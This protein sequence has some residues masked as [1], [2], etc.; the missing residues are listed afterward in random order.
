MNTAVN[1]RFL[2]FLAFFFIAWTFPFGAGTM[3]NLYGIHAADSSNIWAVGEHGVIQKYDGVKW[4]AQPSG[5]TQDL[6]AVTGSSDTGAPLWAVGGTPDGTGVVLQS[7]DRVSWTQSLTPSHALFGVWALDSSHAWAVGQTGAIW[8][9]NG[10]TWSAQSSGVST[11]LEAVFGI[12]AAHVWAVGDSGTILFW[13]GA[14]WA[15]QASPLSTSLLALWGTDASHIWAVGQ[16]AI[17]FWNGATWALQKDLTATPGTVLNGIAGTNATHLRAAGFQG[18][19]PYALVSTDGLTWTSD[20]LSLAIP[21]YALAQIG[22]R[23]YA[24]GQHGAAA[25]TP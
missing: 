17:L 15:T 12:D 24:V 2:S 23:Y 18:S 1:F 7:R 6:Y 11:P 10:S 19:S 5:I 8:F 4:T 21:S 16:S 14:T 3:D 13:D 9:Y 25:F 22:G 20:T